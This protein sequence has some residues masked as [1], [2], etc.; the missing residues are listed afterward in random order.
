MTLTV[1]L[2]PELVNALRELAGSTGQDLDSTIAA[3]LGEQLQR[4]TLPD[5]PPSRCSPT[6]TQLLRQIQQGLPEETWQRYHELIARREAETLTDAE[7]AE[8]VR[9]ADAV[10]GWNVRRLELASE[11]A[12]WRG[13]PWDAIV[14]EPHVV[15]LNR[16]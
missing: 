5:A 6:E 2:A 1:N 16:A 15:A 9:L 3:L 4:R 13:V 7:Q 10:E 8:L 12:Q 11:L 14:E